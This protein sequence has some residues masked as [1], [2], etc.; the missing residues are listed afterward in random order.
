M[1]SPPVLIH[2]RR[3]A[4]LVLLLGVGLGGVGERQKVRG[5]RGGKS[6]AIV[7]T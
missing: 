6:M 2:L 5:G 1:K 4:G 7:A 3:G